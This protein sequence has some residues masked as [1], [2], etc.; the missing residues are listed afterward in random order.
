LLSVDASSPY[1]LADG[2]TPLP[3]DDLTLQVTESTRRGAPMAPI[4]SGEASDLAMVADIAEQGS[5]SARFRLERSVEQ[6]AFGFT[7]QR[8]LAGLGLAGAR[9]L[10]FL[11]AEEGMR[12]VAYLLV[13]VADGTWTIEECGDRDATGA[14]VGAILQAMV[15]REPAEARPVIRGWLPRGFLPPQVTVL[16]SAPAQ[17]RLLMRALRTT[18]ALPGMAAADVHCWRTD[19]M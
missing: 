15:A 4:R 2:F 13:T 1:V 10:Q 3:I 5:R 6:V 14:R 8:L 7:R 9:Q 12:A 11:V 17:A 18:A 16:N 19:L